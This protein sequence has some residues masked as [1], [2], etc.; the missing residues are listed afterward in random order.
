M[1]FWFLVLGSF[2]HKP[3]YMKII[4]SCFTVIFC[5]QLSAQ[6]TTK[7]PVTDKLPGINCDNTVTNTLPADA[8]DRSPS[9]CEIQFDWK[10]RAAIRDA[11]RKTLSNF[12]AA[13]WIISDTAVEKLEEVGKGTEKNFFSLSYDFKI[14]LAPQSLTYKNWYEKYQAQMEEMKNPKEDSYKKFADLM[15]RMNNSIHIRFLVRINNVSHSIYFMKGGQQVLPVPGAVYAV[16]GPKVSALTGG[17][18]ENAMDA[19]LIVFG[20]QEPSLRAEPGGGS[21]FYLVNSFPK[22]VSH[23]TVQNIS[24]R[25]ECNNELLQIILKDTDFKG[26]AELISH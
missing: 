25:I 7:K 18:E 2:R 14:D 5:L 6:T 19:C 22:N 23:L 10:V 26:I 8:P 9:E 17:G 21:S 24:I 11:F 13:D 16:R 4:L 20:N 1:I 3:A 15:Y 12:P